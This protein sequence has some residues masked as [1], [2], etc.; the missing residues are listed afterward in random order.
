MSTCIGNESANRTDAPGRARGGTVRAK[1]WSYH[2]NSS[3][4]GAGGERLRLR[5]SVTYLIN[6][7]FAHQNI[8]EIAAR[9]VRKPVSTGS[10]STCEDAVLQTNITPLNARTQDQGVF[11]CL[12][13]VIIIKRAICESVRQ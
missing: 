5:R 12:C 6:Y 2:H 11:L 4:R 13:Q 1:I 3:R 8:G 7:N 10:G 9:S